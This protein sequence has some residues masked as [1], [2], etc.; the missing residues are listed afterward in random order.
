M[1]VVA[2]FEIDRVEQSVMHRPVK[3][4]CAHCGKVI[5]WLSFEELAGLAKEPDKPLSPGLLC[6]DCYDRQ[7]DVCGQVFETVK[8]G[9][10]RMNRHGEQR[11]KI[12]RLEEEQRTEEMA[13][14]I[15]DMIANE[16]LITLTKFT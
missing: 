7:C 5:G 13:E 11:C 6:F 10:L 14:A 2:K 1:L 16:Y 12:C 3:T 15:A 8:G 9:G 4:T